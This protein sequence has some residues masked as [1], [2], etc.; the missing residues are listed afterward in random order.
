VS[1]LGLVWRLARFSPWHYAA[2]GGLIVLAAYLL[3]LVP[4]LVVRQVLDALTGRAAAGWNVA[5]LLVL[6][7]AFSV[8]R[9]LVEMCAHIAEPSL[10]VVVG[11][12]LRRN[13]LERVL[14][15][16]GA[17]A[18]P[19]S[20]GEAIGRFRNDVEEVAWFLTWTADPIGQVIAFVAALAI[21]AWV[22]PWLTL[23]V[24]L[25]VL[26]VVALVHRTRS[27]VRAYREANQQAIGDV[28]GLLGELFGAALA[29]KVA[30]AE[31]LVVEYLGAINERRRVASLRDAVFS[32]FVSGVSRNAAN[33][34]TGVLLLAGAEAMRAGRFSVGDFALF[35]SYM[36]WL[37]Q[38]LSFVGEFM[39]KHRQTGVSLE[40]L[41]ALMQGAPPERLARAAPIYLRHGP[42]PPPEPVRTAADRL[43][44][45][46]AR[47]L[48][49]RYP[50][51]ERG[52]EA[53]DLTIERGS[54]TVV[55]GRIGAG[56]TTLLRV[57]LG[58]LPADGGQIRWNGVPVE[59]PG[60]FLVPPRAAY[61]P[62]VPRL[63]SETLR[64]NV[65]M[66]LPDRDG[67]LARAIRAAAMERDVPELERGLETPIGPRGVR[68]SGGQVQRAA[69]A[70]MLVR[71]PELLVVD[72]LSSALDVETELQLWQR[73]AE[74]DATI[75]AVSH[76][77]AALRRADQIVVM[78]E[79]RVVDRGRLD[80][81]LVRCAEMR[82]LWESG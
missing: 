50:G 17:R 54:F 5:S 18:L 36:G 6:L 49:Y 74:R 26:A 62:Q 77:P 59:D 75:L 68:L 41:Q 24:F 45:L 22:D 1:T 32:H 81:L 44:R 9:G 25:P 16:P 65:L 42:P 39:T 56:K 82:R 61:A 47:G 63:F 12:L 28:T 34:G 40:R 14:E 79:G 60:T 58:L 80:D 51:G 21:L 66:G 29:V 3:P 48:C 10:H 64:D 7:A 23:F 35:V 78:V 13:M 37:A 2:S 33:L 27:R 53:V 4:G 38:T 71:E 70:R 57:L 19:G 43:E 73:V 11:T 72:D 67:R 20:T 30:G 46:E 55:T 8:V 15:R 76:R 69:A 31:A 52:I